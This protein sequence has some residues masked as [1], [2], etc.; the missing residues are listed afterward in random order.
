[1]KKFLFL[2]VSLSL[3]LVACKETVQEQFKAGKGP[4][5]PSENTEKSFEAKVRSSLGK[6]ELLKAMNDV[7]KTLRVGQS[8]F[9]N[10][11]VRTA[12][13]SEVV[14]TTIDG[15]VFLI[16]EKTDVE[17][18]TDLQKSVRGEVNMFIRNGNIQFDVQKQ[19]KTQYSFRTG[20]ATASIRGTA[21]FVGSLDGQLVASL[22]EGLVDVTSADGKVASIRENQTILVTKSGETKTLQLESSGTPALFAAMDEMA[23]NGSLANMEEMEKSLQTFDSGYVAKRNAFTENL[24]FEPIS[25]PAKITSPS[26]TLKAKLTPGVFVTVMG[27]TDTVPASGEYERTFNW[28]ESTHGAKRFI[29]I[30][31]DGSVEVACNTWNT[32]YVSGNVE[33]TPAVEPVKDSLSSSESQVAPSADSVSKVVRVQRPPKLHGLAIDL[34]PLDGGEVLE[35]D[36]YGRDTLEIIRLPEGDDSVVVEQQILL[37]GIGQGEIEKIDTIFIFRK[38]EVEEVIT[39]I[40]GLSYTR[41]FVFQKDEVSKFE[42]A[43]KL[44]DGTYVVGFKTYVID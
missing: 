1:M 24:V 12:A 14:L 16:S 11:R 3:T 25:I 40:S 17:F 26:I 33:E 6:I 22:K 18:N 19:K 2:L 31:S 42:V 34:P 28:D 38:G 8:V 30:C 21:G 23:K 36:A 5:V 7:W 20:S 29:A 39:D 9:G 41:K 10:D 37:S 35:K 32:E 4:A 15:T 13:E 44:K 27:V 43:A